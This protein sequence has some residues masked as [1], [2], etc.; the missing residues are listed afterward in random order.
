MVEEMT[1]KKNHRIWRA[2]AAEP[3]RGGIT[4]TPQLQVR[5]ACSQTANRIMTQLEIQTLL[6]GIQYFK[7]PIHKKR[8]HTTCPHLC[9]TA[10]P[11]CCAWQVADPSE[12]DLSTGP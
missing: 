9:P 10:P 5:A 4:G 7:N 11:G 3:V 12:Q 8:K 1:Q 2:M 6:K